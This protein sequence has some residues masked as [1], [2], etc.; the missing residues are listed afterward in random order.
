MM[1]PRICAALAALAIMVLAPSAWADVKQGVDAWAQGDYAKAFKIWQPL[2]A[3]GD[4]DA[5]YNIAQAYKWGRGVPQDMNAAL[6]WY[7]KAAVQGHQQAEDNVGLLLFQQNRRPEAMPYL[8][9]SAERGEARAQY[10]VGIAMFNGDLVQ[11]DWVRAYALMTLASA[12]GVEQAASALS[13]MDRY[14]P[15]QQRRDGLATAVAMEGRKARLASAT[16]VPP[17]PR[18]TAPMR[19]PPANTPIRSAAVPPSQP[20]QAAPAPTAPKK[21]AAM[22][23][24]APAS[25]TWQVQLGAFGDAARAEAQWKTIASKTPGLSAYKH[26]LEKAGAMNR[27]LAGP[28]KTRAEADALCARV[29]AGGGDCIVKPL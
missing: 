6:D 29:K 13:H 5:Q 28:L 8:E 2:A 9:R 21:P 7:S 27:L 11:K 23:T 16:E 10:L 14:I 3:A 4:A 15:D 19:T 18:A 22:P 26:R 25:G 1:K 12:A 17:V 24:P 20:V